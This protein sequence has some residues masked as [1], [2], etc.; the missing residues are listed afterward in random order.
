[1]RKWLSPERVEECRN[2]FRA[3]AIAVE[4]DEGR[5]GLA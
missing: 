2:I 3:E 5:R 4:P 1:M